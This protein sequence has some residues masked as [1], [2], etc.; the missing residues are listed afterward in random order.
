MPAGCQV[1]YSVR[2]QWGTGMTVDLTINNTGGIDINGW[3][4][5]WTFPGDQQIGNLWNG[6]YTQSGQD[7]TVTN[8]S[9]NAVIGANG[10]SV[11]LGF[12]ASYTGVNASPSNFTVNGMVCG[13]TLILPT[14]TP[15]SRNAL[16]AGPT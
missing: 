11:V 7:V 8:L 2:D 1:V 5:A 9:Y 3:T 13:S 14:A 15:Y 12:N 10:G 16:F 4:L 6:S